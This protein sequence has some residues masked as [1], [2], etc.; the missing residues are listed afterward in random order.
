MYITFFALLILYIVVRN[1]GT[2]MKMKKYRKHVREVE[3]QV[4]TCVLSTY[5]MCPRQ[6]KYRHSVQF[7]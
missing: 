4:S 6:I 2:Y 1:T 5:Y 3:S 7:T